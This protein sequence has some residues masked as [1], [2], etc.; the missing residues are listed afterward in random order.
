MPQLTEG[1][2]RDLVEGG[3]ALG[4]RSE[5]GQPD[6][7]PVEGAIHPETGCEQSGPASA[8][9]VREESCR[10]GGDAPVDGKVRPE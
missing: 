1:V 5:R 2:V 7:L 8:T 3:F 10:G 6:T 9:P 4:D